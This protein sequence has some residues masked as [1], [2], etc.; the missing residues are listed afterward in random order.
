MAKTVLNGRYELGDEV[1][2]GGMAVTYRARDTLLNRVVAVK[3]MREQFSSDPDF[4]ER[5]RREAQAAANLTHENIAGI[6]DTGA[7][8]GR[9]YIVMEFV[10]GENLEQ[11]LRRHGT[12]DPATVLSVA[13]QVTAALDAAH[14]RGIV[15]RD[16]KPHNILITPEGRVKVTDFGIAKALSASSDTETGIIMGSVHYFSPEQARGDPTGPQSDLYSLGVVM[17]EALTGRRPFEG[18]NP[19][20]V[21]HKQIY[22]QPP[23]PSDYRTAVPEHLE[24]I[25]LRLL[26]KSLARRYPSAAELRRDLEAAREHLSGAGRRGRGARRQGRGAAVWVLAVAAVAIVCAGAYLYTVWQ[27]ESRKISVPTLVGLD[28]SS[29]QRLLA[30]AGLRYRA[31]PDGIYADVEAGL[32]ARQEPEAQ[33]RVERDTPVTVWL[34]LGAKYATVPDVARMSR[35]Q[36]ARRLEQ[37]GLR[38]GQVLEQY[39]DRVPVG[40]VVASEPAAGRQT[41]KMAPVALVISKGPPPVVPPPGGVVEGTAEATIT[42]TVPDDVGSDQVQV[43]VEVVDD[44]GK[45]VLYDAPHM[46]GDELPPL[47]VRYA[48]RAI[49][50]VFIDGKERWS[51]IFVAEPAAG[52]KPG[53]ASGEKP[54]N[55]GDHSPS[56]AGDKASS[57]RSGSKSPTGGGGDAGSRW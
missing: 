50:R 48:G 6:Y 20:A 52:E 49:A 33:T 22:D 9:H 41:G 38:V 37:A 56:V 57:P 27:R 25:I 7:D 32:I 24:N 35:A 28:P 31:E 54:G 16:I 14:R 11:R 34:S 53:A 18:E 29:A 3:V 39:D 15:H 36:A 45:R 44:N 47:K 8:A 40:Y 13:L 21:A 5:F 43:R 19:V 1:G 2:K 10:E 4:V 46:A 23:L 17:F 26:E 12:L 51:Q 30:D 55:A 42:Y